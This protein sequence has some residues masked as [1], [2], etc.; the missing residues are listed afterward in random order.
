MMRVE[1]V[2]KYLKESEC[3]QN[4]GESYQKYHDSVLNLA[5]E[6]LEKQIPS[7][8]LNKRIRNE[9]LIGSCPTCKMKWNVGYWE[10]YCSNCGQ[11]L[12]WS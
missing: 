4:Q 2:I 6:T 3:D 5:I 8:P 10:K 12:D 9:E 11:K 7:V 1:E